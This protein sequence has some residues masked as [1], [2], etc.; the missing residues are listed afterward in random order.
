MPD[1]LIS[2]RNIFT[3]SGK[4]PFEGG[5][6]IK[7]GIIA[8][9]IDSP[10]HDAGRFEEAEVIDCGERLILPGFC[11]SHIH[12]FLGSIQSR[13]A[14]L[15]DCNSEAD[16]VRSA[17]DYYEAQPDKTGGSDWV[18]GFG[19][20]NYNWSDKTLPDKHS[21]DKVF[22]SRPACMFNEEMHSAWL[23][24]AALRAA[25]ITR[26][27]P[28][29]PLGTIFFDKDGEPSGYLLEPDA[30][31]PVFDTAFKL[32][33]EGEQN[34][35][36]K[37]L[38]TSAD[39]GITSFSDI[40]IFNTMKCSVYE[41]L[42]EADELNCRI[43][44]VFPLNTDFDEL[45]ELRRKY[46]SDFLRFSGVK[47]FL[48]GTAPMYTGVLVEPYADRPDFNAVP[49]INIDSTIK[50][51]IRLDAEGIRIR[52]HACGAGAV[53]LG[54]DI[55]EEVRKINGFNDTRHTIEHI[56]NIHPDDIPR[57]SRLGVT[58]SVQPDHLW[59]ETYDGHPFHTLLG[60]KRCRWVWPFKSLLDSG[61]ELAFGTD[62]PVSP[63]NPMQGIY[64]ALS[65]L[66]EDGK[67]EGGWNP[68]EKL[69]LTEAVTL[70]TAGSSR[71]MYDENLTGRLSPGMAA[72][73]A[74]T[75]GNLFEMSPD[76]IR[77]TKIYMT[78]SAG[79]IVKEPG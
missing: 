31:Q 40:Q 76:E 47:E 63:L 15:T 3:S 56:E 36:R 16:C 50:K 29:P 65:R 59:S 45:L 41:D 5:I 39:Y 72:D 2:S 23:N 60:E 37:L 43:R 13:S 25:G 44:P 49:L 53:R 8:E 77:R 70:Y 42:L 58:A 19:W 67:P 34:L 10:V 46:N 38:Q 4:P 62:F 20:N 51:A 1:L 9:V 22:G 71:Q 66:H 73:I 57:F 68:Q 27:T 75:D 78:I 30:M 79:R 21:L 28:Q 55:F 33:T 26:N 14:D 12:G 7:N 48:D 54:L 32:P 18:I 35:C 69:S 6:F 52:F 11:D 17:F 64:R 74:V 61:A 24:S